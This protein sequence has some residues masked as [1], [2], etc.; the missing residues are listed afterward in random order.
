VR[1]FIRPAL[2]W[3]PSAHHLSVLPKILSAAAMINDINVLFAVVMQ[4]CMA[5]AQY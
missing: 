1:F 4:Y 5:R 2:F 3:K